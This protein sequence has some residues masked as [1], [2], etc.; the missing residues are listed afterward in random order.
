MLIGRKHNP[1]FQ[2]ISKWD[3]K[4]TIAV[5]VLISAVLNIGHGFQYQLND[6]TLY[7]WHPDAYYDIY[8]KRS[9][10][11]DLAVDNS[12]PLYIYFILYFIINYFVFFIAN[13][14]VEVTIVRKLHSELADK[15]KRIADMKIKPESEE[16]PSLVIITKPV[17]SR[18]KRRQEVEE[19]AERR[20]IVM[21]IL[22]AVVNF[23]FRLPELLVL[24]SQ[25][26]PLFGFN[27][28]WWFFYTFP[29]LAIFPTDFGYF[30][31]ILTFSTN[32]IIYY[33]FN[34]KFKQTF[35][36]WTHAKKRH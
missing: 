15:K 20:S 31:Y 28:I 18:K 5:T 12:L 36:E 6:G 3:L 2:T 24:L 35:S 19:G 21:V 8:V 32:F 22:N 9:Y 34:L 25:S 26:E 16:K 27:A 23:F 10:P 4:W 11:N 29:S 30:A 14:C 1:L 17:F 7:T 13:T 33:L